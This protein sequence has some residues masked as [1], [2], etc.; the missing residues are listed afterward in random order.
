MQFLLTLDGEVWGVLECRPCL[1]YKLNNF[2]KNRDTNHAL[3]RISTLLLRMLPLIYWQ[4]A[5]PVTL[6]SVSCYQ[7]LFTLGRSKVNL[8]LRIIYF[9]TQNDPSLLIPSGCAPG[10]RP[11]VCPGLSSSCLQRKMEG[12]TCFCVWGLQAIK[13]ALLSLEGAD[14]LTLK[15]RRARCQGVLILIGQM[16]KVTI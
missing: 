2:W 9:S 4:T 3:Q 11:S 12:V 8:G 7:H 13:R 16:I 1:I 15:R 6:V 10:N 14:W 5:N